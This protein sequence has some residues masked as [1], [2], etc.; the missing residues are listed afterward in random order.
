[1]WFNLSVLEKK[2]KRKKKEVED[3]SYVDDPG[4]P[5]DEGKLVLI[6]YLFEHMCICYPS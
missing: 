6:C 5:L 1:L 3:E 4:E 2:Y